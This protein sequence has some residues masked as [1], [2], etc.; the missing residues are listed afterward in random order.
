M[1]FV[2]LN[3]YAEN[4]IKTDLP[5]TKGHL[6]SDVQYVVVTDPQSNR[7]SAS[8]LNVRDILLSRCNLQQSSVR[9]PSHRGA[10]LESNN[11][12]TAK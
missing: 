9:M 8:S 4:Q 1:G 6:H 3:R 5:S 12:T 2:F 7:S 10:Q 11:A